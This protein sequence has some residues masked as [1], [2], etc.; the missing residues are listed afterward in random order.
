MLAAIDAMASS[1]SPSLDSLTGPLP[2]SSLVVD[3]CSSSSDNSSLVGCCLVETNLIAACS[4][5]GSS[6][7]GGSHSSAS[8][9]SS[10]TSPQTS[11][12]VAS[13]PT[14]CYVCNDTLDA[15]R[16]LT[17]FHSFCADCIDKLVVVDGCDVT[18]SP[19]G[20]FGLGGVGKVVCPKCSSETVLPPSGVGGLLPDYVAVGLLAAESQSAVIAEVNAV[21]CQG[22]KGKES[23]AVARCYDCAHF[24]CA[25]C[26]MAHQYMHCFEGHTYYPLGDLQNGGI[27]LDELK[28]SFFPL[29]SLIKQ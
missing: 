4:A 22:C 24:L 7:S 10:A 16:V 2:V 11:L 3:A 25:N 18:G 17:C 15:P 29:I 27:K 26:V 8:S 13:H 14:K 12:S 28:V 1:P 9:T 19:T 6:I 21:S 23:N 20:I 5:S